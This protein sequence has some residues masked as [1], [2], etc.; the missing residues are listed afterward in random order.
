MPDGTEADRTQLH[1]ATL[2]APIYRWMLGDLPSAVERS[3]AELA[4]L[5]VGAAGPGAR[6]LDLGAGLGLQTIP[7]AGFGYEVTAVDASEPLLSELS[8]AC[9]R[10]R[11]VRAD[12]ADVDAYMTG[13]YRVVVCM[14]DTLTHLRSPDEMRAVLRTASAHLEPGG[15][16]VL[17]FRDYSGVPRRSTERFI[18][19]R[20]DAERVLTCFL[21]YGSATVTVTDVVHERSADGW[22]M[23]AS[24]YEKLRI[25][26]S[27]VTTVLGAA[28]LSVERCDSIDGR[29]SVVARRR[30][31]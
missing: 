18:L 30:V 10:A 13:T 7:L 27:D 28:G 24:E 16:L 6:A 12:L 21:E 29:V 4:R 15:I 20:A 23:R 25:A 8:A 5:G 2:L 1:Y 31:R 3:R 14:G 22:S 17:T 26:P 11:V 19:V 9:P